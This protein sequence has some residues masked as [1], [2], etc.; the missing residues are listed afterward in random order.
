MNKQVTRNIIRAVF[1]L[2]IQV[3]LLKRNL[4]L[5]EFNYVHLTVYSVIIAMFP[6]NW[7]RTLIIFLGFATGLF[8]DIFYDSIGVHAGATTFIAYVRYYILNWMSPTEGYKKDSL[9]AYQLGVPWF[10]TY[11]AI[12]I[13]LHLI[14]LYSLEAFSFVYLKEII[15]RTVFSFIASLF[16][17]MFGSLIFNP[18]Y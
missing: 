18:K 15:L 13:F 7:N 10:F 2:A 16:L 6:Y 14:F 9:T 12:I 5:G 1:I 17:V 11:V 8:V 3:I 4:T